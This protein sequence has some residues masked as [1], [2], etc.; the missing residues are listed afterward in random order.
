VEDDI[1][2]DNMGNLS[3]NLSVNI[4]FIVQYCSTCTVEDTTFEAEDDKIDDS[5]HVLCYLS[6]I[7]QL[8][9]NMGNLSTNLSGRIS[10]I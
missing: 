7:L 1:L 6:T 10:F 3:T 2:N 9:D 4:S 5:I 8:N